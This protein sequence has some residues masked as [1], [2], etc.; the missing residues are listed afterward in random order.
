MMRIQSSWSPLYDQNPQTFVA[1]IF[2]AKPSDFR[3]QK[4]RIGYTARYPPHIS[5]R[6]LP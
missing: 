5:V 3:T 6:V 4:R 2:Q 1:N